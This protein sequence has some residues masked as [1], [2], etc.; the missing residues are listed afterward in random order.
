MKKLLLL[1][2]FL[3]FTSIVIYLL[4]S[5]TSPTPNISTIFKPKV[6][7]IAIQPFKG[8]SNKYI[9]ETESVVQEFYQLETTVL[10]TIDLPKNAYY[11]PRN[12]YRADTLIRFLRHEKPIKYDHILG[13]THR[14]ISTTKGKHKDWGIM[15]LGFRPGASCVIS[16]FRIRKA[17]RNE[18]HFVERFRKVI[19]H[20]I[21]HNLGLKHCTYHEKCLMKDALGK[22]TTVDT[23]DEWLCDN[24]RRKIKGLVDI[25]N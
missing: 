19:L 18:Q 7:N 3:F 20:E 16:T 1:I 10:P 6:K 5:P 4:I 8:V 22:V 15:G 11:A 21:G 12:R 2:L 25:K 23:A 14:D 24:C 17:T 9:K 13:L